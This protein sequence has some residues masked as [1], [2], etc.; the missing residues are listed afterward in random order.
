V[1]H[2]SPSHDPP[3]LVVGAHPLQPAARQ[4]PGQAAPLPEGAA[5]S[6]PHLLGVLALELPHVEQLVAIRIAD[7][8][9][10]ATA[11]AKVGTRTLATLCGMDRNTLKRALTRLEDA[12]VIAREGEVYRV[13]CAPVYRKT[14][15]ADSAQVGAERTQGGGAAHPHPVFSGLLPEK[16]RAGVGAQRTRAGQEGDAER[17][18]GAQSTQ[19]ARWARLEAIRAISE[20]AYNTALKL[21]LRDGLIP[22]TTIGRRASAPVIDALGPARA[23]AAREGR[24]AVAK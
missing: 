22:V 6:I 15:G 2:E 18:R 3:Y 7:R 4:A 23:L 17:T 11:V 12:Q 8:A 10:K 16:E 20:E 13:R 19:A 14:A 5:M 9:D 21:E 1:R 24:C